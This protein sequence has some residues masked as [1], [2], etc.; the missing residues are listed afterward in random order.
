M[1][2]P[3]RNERVDKIL[4][5]LFGCSTTK[6]SNVAKCKTLIP[7]EEEIVGFAYWNKDAKRVSLL[8]TRVIKQSVSRGRDRDLFV[9]D[10]FRRGVITF[11]FRNKDVSQLGFQFIQPWDGNL[12]AYATKAVGVDG[13]WNP[14]RENDRGRAAP[15]DRFANHAADPHEESAESTC[16]DALDQCP[17]ERKPDTAEP[18]RNNSKAGSASP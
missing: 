9:L 13:N 7:P 14:D 8:N 15:H 1:G 12:F 2:A 6:I 11:E 3:V 17:N 4:I 10:R 18:Y 16:A 5:H